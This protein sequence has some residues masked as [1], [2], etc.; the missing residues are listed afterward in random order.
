MQEYFFAYG[1]MHD[2]T[3]YGHQQAY[4]L[5][6]VVKWQ[7]SCASWHDIGLRGP[8]GSRKDF[9]FFRKNRPVKMLELIPNWTPHGLIFVKVLIE[10][11]K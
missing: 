1:R 6:G 10:K 7:S 8:Q 9:Q 11:L 5:P 2:R 3:V 4:S